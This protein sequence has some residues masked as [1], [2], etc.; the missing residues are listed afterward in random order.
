MFKK[1]ILLLLLVA[2]MAL[3]AQE[4]IAYINSQEVFMKM[5][6]LKDVESKIAAKRETLQKSFDALQTEYQAKLEEFNKL[7]EAIQKDSTAVSEADILDAQKALQQLQE[8]IQTRQ[9]N[10]SAELEKTQQEL[11]TPL[12]EKMVKAVK[13]VGAEQNF[14]Y[15]IDVAALPYISP[16]AVDA[17]KFV[18]TK[19]G[20]VN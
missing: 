9:E 18:K 11:L 8:R 2:P 4:K 10:A 3:V 6:E 20:I 16:N 17:T 13:E 15:I 19:L 12:Q 14:L 5:P 1:L 7:I